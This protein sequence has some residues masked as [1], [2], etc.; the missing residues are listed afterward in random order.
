MIVFVIWFGST[1][2]LRLSKSHALP[3]QPNRCKTKASH[4]LAT[5]IFPMP[6]AD[7][8]A[9]VGY[10]LFQQKTFRDLHYQLDFTVY[11]MVVYHHEP[12]L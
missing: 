7:W 1:M 3:S 10:L 9:L 5:F 2:H 4:Y 8:Q 6:Q 12:C 11:N